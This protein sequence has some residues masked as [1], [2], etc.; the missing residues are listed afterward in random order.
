M[1]IVW[2]DHQRTFQRHKRDFIDDINSEKM[3][4]RDKRIFNSD[5]YVNEIEK[6]LFNDELWNEEWYMVIIF[7]SKS[8]FIITNKNIKQ[9][10]SMTSTQLLLNL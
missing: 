6:K 7:V 1:K 10:S 5:N 2:V 8:I 3:L 9:N 4:I